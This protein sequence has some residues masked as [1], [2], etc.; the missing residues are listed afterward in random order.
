M[1]ENLLQFRFLKV[2]QLLVFHAQ[3]FPNLQQGR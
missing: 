1:K 2:T 3:E